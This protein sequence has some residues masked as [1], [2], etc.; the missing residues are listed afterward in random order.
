MAKRI[1]GSLALQNQSQLQLLDA[2]SSHSVNLQSPFSLDGDITFSLPSSLG[3]N[4]QLMGT[5]G[6]GQLSFSFISNSNVA[7]NAA[8]AMSKLASVAAGKALVSDSSGV[9]SAS[10]ITGTELG[11]LSGV[12]G[13][14]QSQLDSEV[15]ARQ[16]AVAN[17]VSARQ[18]AV[19]AEQDARVAADSAE[20]DARIAAIASEAGAR[21]AADTQEAT[22]RAAADAHERSDRQAAVQAEADARAAAVAQEKSDREAAISSEQSARQAAD[23][24]LASRLNV[25]EGTGEGSVKKAKADAIAYTD[26][27]VAAL[28]NS[29]PEVL[30]TLKELADA[31]GDDANFAT[32]I[33]NQIGAEA[34]ARTAADAQEKADRIA[35]VSAEA[36]ARAQAD[37]SESSAR[38]AA[39]AAEATAR[40]NADAALGSRIDNLNTSQ[41]AENSAHLYFT[42]SRAQVATIM[43]NTDG[44]GE[45]TNKTYS[46]RVLNQSFSDLS[47]SID[48]LLQNASNSSQAAITSL[49]GDLNAAVASLQSDLATEHTARQTADTSE[50]TARIAADAALSSSISQEVSDRQAA[51]SSEATARAQAVSTEAAARQAADAS[52][53]TARQAADAA[54]ASARQAADKDLQDALSAEVSARQAADTSEANARS[55]ADAALQTG[56]NQEASAR[57]AADMA[58]SGRLD[59]I[60]GTGAGSVKKALADSKSYTD[61]SVAALVASAPEVLNTLKELAD[62]IG[63][64][65]NFATTIANQIGVEKSAREAADL[66]EKNARE[67]AMAAEVSARQAAD[68]QEATARSNA[69]SSE[70]S[71]RTA[72]DAKLTSDLSDEVAARIAAV[73]SEASARA[74]AVTAEANARATA[75]ATE[76]AA[77]IAGDA[78]VQAYF[79]SFRYKTDW[80]T[81]DG[82]SKSISHGMGTTDIIVQVFDKADGQS[83][84][85]EVDR[86]SSGSLTLISSTA[87][88]A[89]GWRVLLLKV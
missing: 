58:L 47:Q 46:A 70:A 57:G 77:R 36:T 25:V 2:L 67:A 37:S 26:A 56:L 72:A 66:S 50:A 10:S 68:S 27:Q 1:Y 43:D 55:S 20:Q 48:V 71:A 32:S 16:T 22:A 69:I 29:A 86:S 78:A 39:D 84:D 45:E 14:V 79:D 5:D 6:A 30:N 74:S 38:Q 19:K 53:V 41:V 33:S 60:E 61:S 63:D 31:I 15:S 44:S 23:S 80:V 4:F 73:S 11:R 7:G 13:N 3:S 35:A 87:P 54:E 76:Q 34:T 83:L 24:A 42:D 89:S 17:E 81:G 18:A 8:I 28:V 21:Q 88:G 62:A 82:V 9:V 65:A 64:D 85:V 40:G 12:T 52:E 49:Q 51:V 59:V 75:D